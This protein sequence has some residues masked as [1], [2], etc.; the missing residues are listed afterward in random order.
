M[1]SLQGPERV[2]DRCNN[3]SVLQQAGLKL[4]VLAACVIHEHALDLGTLVTTDI[5][6]YFNGTR[7]IHTLNLMVFAMTRLRI[8]GKHRSREVHA[9]QC[10]PNR[11]FPIFCSALT[12]SS[13]PARLRSFCS[14]AVE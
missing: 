14:I 3:G 9:I 2:N 13:S 12:G 6:K 10:V 7:W 5:P 4:E 1:G 8:L 11:V